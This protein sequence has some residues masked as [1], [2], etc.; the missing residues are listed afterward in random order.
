MEEA[1]F[2]LDRFI[3]EVPPEE[4][5]EAVKEFD[6]N[7]VSSDGDTVRVFCE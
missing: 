7:I 4:L 1:G 5:L 3:D 2:D 6:V